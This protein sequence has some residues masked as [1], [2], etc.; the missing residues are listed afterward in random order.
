MAMYKTCSR[1]GKMHKLGA[2][3]YAN[4]RNYYQAD[5]KVR[6]F[7]NSAEWKRKTEEIRTRDKQLC[8][9]C[10]SRNIF[11]YKN[12]SVHHITPLQED[13]TRRLDNE[14]LITV[15]ETCHRDCESGKI[16]RETQFKLIQEQPEETKRSS[17]DTET[18][19]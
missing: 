12:L 11:N 4:T 18:I 8:Q 19:S 17:S 16:K 2:R 14:N 9:V 13:W 1:C 5:P 3:C 7:R 15:C 6:E 10:L